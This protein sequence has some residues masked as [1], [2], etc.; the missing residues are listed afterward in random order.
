MTNVS[1]EREREMAELSVRLETGLM[2]EGMD[3]LTTPAYP[4]YLHRRSDVRYI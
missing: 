3:Q 2:T 1:R 4:T